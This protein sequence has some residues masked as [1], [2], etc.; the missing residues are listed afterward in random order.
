MKRVNVLTLLA[1]LAVAG[2]VFGGC[3][4]VRP[5]TEL[6]AQRQVNGEIYLPGV[7]QWGGVTVA[8]RFAF[9]EVNPKTHEATGYIS[10]RNYQP[11]PPKGEAYWKLVDS[12]VRYVFFGADAPNGDSNTVVVIT[13]IKAKTGWGQ[14]QPGDYAYFWFRDGG[15][16][17]AD[18]WGMRY[19]KLDPWTE[20]YPA[21]Q[22]PVTAGYF[23]MK[24]MQADSPVL[25]L[26]VEAGDLTIVQ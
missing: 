2:M 13:Q 11:Q 17:G 9:T 19:Y 20:F 23:T 8:L 6:S 7:P 3:Q 5:V 25:P 12:D 22:S 26:N 14:G 15:K 4:P 16:G 1:M 21:E 10:W 24:A 18:Q